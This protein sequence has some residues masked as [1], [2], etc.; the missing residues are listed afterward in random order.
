MHNFKVDF[1]SL[2]GCNTSMTKKNYSLLAILSTAAAVIVHLYL[3]KHHYD[4]KFGLSGDKSLCNINATFNCDAVSA[5]QYSQLFGIPMALLG[6]LTN[7]YLLLLLLVHH[8]KMADNPA[9]VGRYSVHASVLISFI[10]VIMATISI[11]YLGNLC[12]FCI[13]TYALSFLGLLFAFQAQESSVLK[14]LGDDLQDV[15][16]QTRWV[17]ICAALVPVM[18]YIINS[19]VTTNSGFGNFDIVLQESLQNWQSNPSYSFVENRGLVSESRSTPPVMTIVEFADFKCPHCKHA[20]PTLHAF[21]DA[22]PDVKFIY[23]AFPLDGSCSTAAIHP[24]DGTR[25]T[26]VYY[27]L[28]AEKLFKKGW[29]THH[30]IFDHQED[31]FQQMSLDQPMQEVSDLLKMDFSALKSCAASPEI[32]QETRDMSQEGVNAKI[33]GTPAIFVNGKLFEVGRSLPGLQK[34]YDF[35]KKN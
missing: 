31:L 26:L 10:S 34:M 8:F 32:A 27:T 14:H 17:L 9:R 16:I 2:S 33:N 30:W 12:V 13:T 19:A 15:F 22:H 28:C 21:K 4:L 18:G 24:G 25:C 5:S 11:T 35:L 29:D 20:Y 7:A 1:K 6:A 23:K 3:T